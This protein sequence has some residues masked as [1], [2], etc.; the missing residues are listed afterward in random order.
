MNTFIGE[1]DLNLIMSGEKLKRDQW[2]GYWEWKDDT[3]FLHCED[4]HV[5]SINESEDVHSTVSNILQKDWVIANADNCKILKN[6]IEEKII[7]EV[8]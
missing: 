1:F 3:I 2:E 7:K 6:E 4:G 8:F 5:M